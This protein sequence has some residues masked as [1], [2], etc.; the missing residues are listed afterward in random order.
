MEFFDEIFNAPIEARE[1]N[2]V[3]ARDTRCSY[4]AGLSFIAP[5][6]AGAIEHLNARAAEFCGAGI[7][8]ANAYLEIS[9]AGWYIV[10][11]QDGDTQ[12]EYDPGTGETRHCGCGADCIWT[13]WE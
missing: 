2:I 5:L 9:T 1:P 11:W 13:D 8:P 4:K 12:W 3:E 10:C 6:D 7:I